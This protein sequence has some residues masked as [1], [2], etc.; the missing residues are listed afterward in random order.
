MNRP[1]D[2]T[3]RRGFIGAVN[4]HED[5]CL[6]HAHVLK[7]LTD[8]SGLKKVTKNKMDSRNGGSFQKSKHLLALGALT[9]Y[10]NHNKP[11]QIYTDASDYQLWSCIIQDEMHTCGV[12]Q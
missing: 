8:L 2:A 4:F 3:A 7:P 9:A 5:L 11:Y 6:S 10:P 1:R 12:F